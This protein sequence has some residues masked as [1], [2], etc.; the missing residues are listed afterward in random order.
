MRRVSCTRRG[1]KPTIA[2][3][4][5]AVSSRGCSKTFIVCFLSRILEYCRSLEGA[6]E[7]PFARELVARWLE[8]ARED[9]VSEVLDID[10]GGVVFQGE[11][12]SSYWTTPH[13][14]FTWW[15]N[16]VERKKKFRLLKVK[17]AVPPSGVH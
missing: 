8:T 14:F 1:R 16:N 7:F 3:P 10:F 15:K 12:P 5:V 9:C 2:R 13:Q 4:A 11:D 6:P 17:G